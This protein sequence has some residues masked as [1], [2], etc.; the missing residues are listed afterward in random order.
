MDW[1]TGGVSLILS[2]DDLHFGTLTFPAN[3]VTPDA[4]LTPHGERRK[5][6]AWLSNYAKCCHGVQEADGKF[7]AA[8]MKIDFRS[9]LLISDE[10]TNIEPHHAAFIKATLALW[11]KEWLEDKAKGL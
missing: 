3:I 1:P 7:Y 6:L 4:P 10:D 9:A 2:S 11:E 5:R 8:H